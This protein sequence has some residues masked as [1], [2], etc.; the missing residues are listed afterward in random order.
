[1][2][3]SKGRISII[4]NRN[5]QKIFLLGL[6]VSSTA[7]FS[8]IQEERLILNK[9]REPEVKKIEKK[10]TSVETIK[11]Y[12]PE[13]KSAVPVEYDITNVPAVSDFKTSTIQGEDI[14]PKFDSEFQKNYFRAGY[15]NYGKF[16]ADG[17]IS[18]SLENQMEV[19]ANVHYISTEGLKKEYPWS[20]KQSSAA[21]GGFLTSYG[22]S[23]KFNLNAEYN[24]NDY[25]YY[26]IYALQPAADV[27]LSQKTNQFKVNGYYD[28]Y[29]NNILNDARVKSSFLGDKFDA[30]ESNVLV[31]LNLSKH[32]V[33]LPSNDITMNADLGLGI[34]TL[35]SEFAIL[36]KN[37]SNYFNADI[38]PKVTFFNGDSY[39]MLG[40]SF[41]FLNSKNKDLLTMDEVKSDKAYWFP[42]A[43]ILYAATDEFKFYAGV[44]GGLKMNSYASMLQENPYL[45][46][47]QVIKPTE[48]KYNIYFG[49]KGDLNQNLKFDV[50]AGFG[51][52][53]NMLFYEANGLF[54]N[55]ATLNRSAYN[56]ANTFS[57]VYDNGNVSTITGALQYYPL[58]NLTMEAELNFASYR[59]ENLE[60]A[61][62]RPMVKG[63]LGAKYTMLDKKLHLGFKGFLMSERPTNSFRIVEA[64]N[65]NVSNST[66]YEN[67]ENRNDMVAGYADFNLSA[68]YKIHKNFSIFALGNNLMT[69]KYETFKGYKVLGPQIL[70]G[71]KISF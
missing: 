61:Y 27:D 4:M 17:N 50:N 36:N 57:A 18:G 64:P 65:P 53:K 10:K 54:D 43:E 67:V 55:N 47:D 19:G 28:F 3:L 32:A 11:N 25:N 14:S 8:Q 37:Y 15:G 70:G 2:S 45:V 42:K 31:M 29:S 23:G 26:G 69:K 16:Q 13:E 34:E 66:I 63:T 6:L 58:A 71:L 20:S 51:K 41:T 49:L 9:K 39:L 48:T 30:K 59:L 5:I 22:E 12:P 35:N 52:V 24:L 62:N 60:K 1:M 44:D 33:E 56:L 38:A 46:S 68:E 40:S 21:L 7:V